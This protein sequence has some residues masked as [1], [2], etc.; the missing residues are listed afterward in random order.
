MRRSAILCVGLS[1]NYLSMSFIGLLFGKRFMATSMPCKLI[2]KVY[3]YHHYHD[4]RIRRNIVNVE[5]PCRLSFT[6]N[7]ILPRI[8]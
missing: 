5:R 6:E 8:I 4:G 3:M 2:W 7:G 1:D